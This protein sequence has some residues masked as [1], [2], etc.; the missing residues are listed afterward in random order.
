[1][2]P[3]ATCINDLE[4]I[5]QKAMS[6]ADDKDLWLEREKEETGLTRR[7]LKMDGCQDCT[8][9]VRDLRPQIMPPCTEQRTCTLML[10]RERDEDDIVQDDSTAMNAGHQ[11]ARRLAA[12]NG[13]AH[14]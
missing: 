1:M 9:P 4:A 6:V 13:M 14:K 5:G 10:E 11:S 2:I 3:L 12:S 8:T 7:S